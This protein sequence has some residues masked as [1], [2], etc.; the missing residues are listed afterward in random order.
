VTY[1]AATFCIKASILYLYHRVFYVSRRF[2]IILWVVAIFTFLYS[3][4]QGL[5][6]LIQCVPTSAQWDPM[7]KRHCFPIDTSVII[8]AVCNVLTDFI[9][10]ILPM[11][12]LWGLKQPLEQKLKLM[13]MFALGGLYVATL[14]PLSGLY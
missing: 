3:S 5:G 7:I 6:A 13:A 12:L 8:F 11:P 14:T 4:V 2:T 1:Q 9:I 10:L